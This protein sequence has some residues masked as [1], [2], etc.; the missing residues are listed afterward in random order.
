MKCEGGRVVIIVPAKLPY[1]APFKPKLSWQSHCSLARSGTN[2]IN[3]Y[4]EADHLTSDLSS[5]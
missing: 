3:Y 4:T 1:R 2:F 5:D